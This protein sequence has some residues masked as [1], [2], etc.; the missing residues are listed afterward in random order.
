M[1]AREHGLKGVKLGVLQ[2][3][4]RK[5]A[6]H[7]VLVVAWPA[8]FAADSPE[9][10]A[11]KSVA[12]YRLA[13][14]YCAKEAA[15][16][17]LVNLSWTVKYRLCIAKCCMQFYPK[18]HELRVSLEF[19]ERAGGGDNMQLNLPLKRDDEEHQGQKSHRNWAKTKDIDIETQEKITV[20][21]DPW[22][23]SNHFRLIIG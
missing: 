18:I 8:V 15:R 4:G 12:T 21:V 11:V 2:R 16:M 10:Y 19:L 7:G 3:R 13:Y 9:D 22:S 20:D 1:I 17:Y 14:R 23:H 6:S 5:T